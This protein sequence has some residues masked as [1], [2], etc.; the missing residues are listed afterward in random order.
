M[1]KPAKSGQSVHATSV[2]VY[3]KSLT[4]PNTIMTPCYVYQLAVE[5]VCYHVDG[6][7]FICKGNRELGNCIKTG[8]GPTYFPNKA[9]LGQNLALVKQ[10]AH[11]GKTSAKWR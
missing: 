2:I 7:K 6:D 11:L 10:L 5:W 4:V 3:G 1:S 8:K 9:L